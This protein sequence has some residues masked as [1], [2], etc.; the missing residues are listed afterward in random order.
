[1]RVIYVDILLALNLIVNYLLLFAAARL[2]GAVFTG[3]RGLLGAAIGAIYALV[4]LVELP[5]AVLALSKLLVSGIMVGAAFGKRRVT[6]F[7]RLMVFFYA[8]GFAFAGL[9]LLVQMMLTGSEIFYQ[10]G[11]VYYEMPAVWIV[12]SASC[13]FLLVEGVR[14]LVRHG[15][16][17]GFFRAEV[18]F[19]GK[20]A[21]V[22]AMTDT[23]NSLREPF[24]GAPVAVCPVRLLEDI[25]PAEFV[26]AAAEPE[27][28]LPEGMRL[29]PCRTVSGAALLPAFRPDTLFIR[30]GGRRRQAEFM[31]IA[32]SSGEE[33]RMLVGKNMQFI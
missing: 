16:S 20:R 10:N 4:V 21:D 9:M 8:A 5:A 3:K 32:L 2:S 30:Q 15:E 12:A 19:K 18:S 27:L 7:L 28:G 25:L 31:Y 17:E 14:R 33:S 22:P 24:S 6:E 29:V 1:M 13:A 11:V 26:R 23:G